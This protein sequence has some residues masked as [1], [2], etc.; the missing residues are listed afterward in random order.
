MTK[1]SYLF[2][3][4]VIVF[5]NSCIKSEKKEDVVTEKNLV[6]QFTESYLEGVEALEGGDV[7]YAAKKFNEAETLYPQ[8]IMAPN[9]ALMAAY[10]YYVQDYYKDAIAELIRFKR[11]YPYHKHLDYVE[12]L[13]AISYYEQIIDEKKDL[14]SIIKSKKKF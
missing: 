4:F 7:L 12:Y 8:Y 10:S 2:L 3:L 13:I 5:S 14:N 9:A 11:V 1:Y 6:L